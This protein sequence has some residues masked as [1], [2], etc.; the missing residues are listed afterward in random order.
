MEEGDAERKVKRVVKTFGSHCQPLFYFSVLKQSGLPLSKMNTA[1]M[2]KPEM[3]CKYSLTRY[4]ECRSNWKKKSPAQHSNHKIPADCSRSSAAFV[5]SFLDLSL[6]TSLEGS[7]EHSDLNAY[8]A[9]HI[10]I[11]VYYRRYCP[12]YLSEGCRGAS[13]IRAAEQQ[14][15]FV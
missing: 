2:R 6:T 3:T 7:V 8:H 12:M 5:R 13:R 14:N 11:F 10:P 9:S 1:H 4:I 15:Q